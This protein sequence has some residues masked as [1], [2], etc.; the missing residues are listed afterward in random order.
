MRKLVWPVILLLACKSASSPDSPGALVDE[1]AVSPIAH[2][3]YTSFVNPGRLVVRDSG[4]WA[5]VWERTF[6]ERSEV[7]P[8]PAVD[9]SSEMILVALQGSQRSGGYDISIDRVASTAEDLLVQVT[10]TTPD[11][12]CVVTAAL[13]SPAMMVRA[14]T[15]PGPVR[16]VER[17]RVDPCE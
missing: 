11:R 10:T 1:Q 14:P 15:H 5:E 3:L 2:E 4:Q 6:A 17:T 16:F 9:F 8:R 13:T 12:R 7:P